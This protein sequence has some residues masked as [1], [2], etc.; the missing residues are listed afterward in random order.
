[1]GSGRNSA[2]T[3][4][5]FHVLSKEFQV[6]DTTSVLFLQL[7][8]SPCEDPDHGRCYRR[9]RIVFGFFLFFFLKAISGHRWTQTLKATHHWSMPFRA[10]RCLSSSENRAVSVLVNSICTP[11]C[12][13]KKKKKLRIWLYLTRKHK[14]H[15]YLALKACSDSGLIAPPQLISL[16]LDQH[17]GS[18]HHTT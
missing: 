8:S 13:N 14:N 18:S 11:K 4:R 10:S 5:S 17:F 7:P 3:I 9:L 6:F 2:V 1:M 12:K 15:I 16:T